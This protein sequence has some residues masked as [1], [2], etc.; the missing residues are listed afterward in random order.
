MGLY[1]VGC[2]SS[3]YGPEQGPDLRGAV[4]V[5]RKRGMTAIDSEAA[6]TCSVGR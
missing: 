3:K 1:A 5:V 4:H 6:R 2:M